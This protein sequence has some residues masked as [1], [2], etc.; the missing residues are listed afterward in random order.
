MSTATKPPKPSD[1]VVILN[2][3]F[4]SL[5]LETVPLELYGIA[6]SRLQ[7]NR[8]E[9]KS[10]LK[11]YFKDSI[12]DLS[13][14]VY[15]GKIKSG[16]Y[17]VVMDMSAYISHRLENNMHVQ[18]LRRSFSRS[19]PM[20]WLSCHRVVRQSTENLN[21]KPNISVLPRSLVTKEQIDSLFGYPTGVTRRAK[22][23]I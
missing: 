19:F 15:V 23:R 4:E 20:L 17:R 22:V 5:P 12:P 3:D 16:P 10:D 21:K 13:D 2:H 18:V 6:A 8:V 1:F 14:A 7:L 9:L 11:T